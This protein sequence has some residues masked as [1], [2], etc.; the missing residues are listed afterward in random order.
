[1]N[2]KTLFLMYLLL[3]ISSAQADLIKEGCY[4]FNVSEYSEGIDHFI[5][6]MVDGKKQDTMMAS[7]QAKRGDVSH[8]AHFDCKIDEMSSLPRK[9]LCA[10]DNGDFYLNGR[11]DVLVMEFVYINL[12]PHEKGVRLTD[13]FA[14]FRRGS[15]GSSGHTK[16]VSVL[17]RRVACPRASQ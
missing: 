2:L 17:S 15:H 11:S 7:I 9:T 10:A 16:I 1:M 6:I 8:T 12:L 14:F 3:I 13:E 5:L 4:R